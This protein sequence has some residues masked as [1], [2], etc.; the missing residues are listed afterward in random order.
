MRFVIGLL[1][2]F[3]V[4]MAGA[5]LF[6]PDRSKRIEATWTA[7]PG[8]SGNG[9]S[10]NGNTMSAIRRALRSLQDQFNTAMEEAKQA[11]EE[12]E[13]EMRARYEKAAGKPAAKA[14]AAKKK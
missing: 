10:Q 12:T 14:A 4:G 5:I 3:G 1:I 7:S 6:A 13:A 11:S 9:L 8:A 2:G